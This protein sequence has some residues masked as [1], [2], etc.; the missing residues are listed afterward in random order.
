MKRKK[1]KTACA[2][3]LAAVVYT[4]GAEGTGSVRRKS[5]CRFC[6][7][8]KTQRKPEDSRRLQMGKSCRTD[9]DCLRKHRKILENPASPAAEETAGQPTET[10]PAPPSQ[11]PGETVEISEPTEPPE[12]DFSSGDQEELPE[13]T[14]GSPESSGR[15][16]KKD[17]PQIPDQPESPGMPEKPQQGGPEVR[18][19]ALYISRE[20]LKKGIRSDSDFTITILLK[21]TWET[22]KIQ[23]G[24]LNL[25]LPEG[26]YLHSSY[27]KETLDFSDIQPGSLQETA[28]E[29]SGRTAE[30]GRA[31]SEAEGEDVIPA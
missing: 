2:A 5:I 24:K 11:I 7:I 10:A 27:E 15:P 12:E 26:L 16:P 17:F 6:R 25:E 3:A 20:K 22:G 8:L 30:R 31:D 28:S 23:N 13:T 9:R 19:G 4:D 18:P 14:G 1:G 29:A 21:N